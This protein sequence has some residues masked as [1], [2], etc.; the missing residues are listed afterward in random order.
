MLVFA[1]FG[2][3]RTC[4]MSELWLFF[5]LSPN[6]GITGVR[7]ALVAALVQHPSCS[8]SSHPS[9]RDR[10]SAR[11]RVGG[12]IAPGAIFQDGTNSFELVYFDLSHVHCFEG[13]EVV[14][15]MLNRLRSMCFTAVFLVPPSS[16]WS[17]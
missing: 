4:S 7:R 10:F 9:F 17:R 14:T 15:D 16:K 13:K 1:E 5:L 6:F 8:G 12:G 11:V 2:A 3:S